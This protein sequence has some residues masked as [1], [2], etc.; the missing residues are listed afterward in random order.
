MNYKTFK[1][2]VFDNIKDRLPKEYQDYDMKFQTVRKGSGKEYEALMIGPK[3]RRLSVVPALNITAAFENYEN[4]MDFDD[5]M[6]IGMGINEGYTEY[7][8][9]L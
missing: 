5:G 6:G 9:T 1:K 2:K 7:L 3:D 8:L 4:G